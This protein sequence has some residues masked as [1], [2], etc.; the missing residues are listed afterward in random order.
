[1]DGTVRL[2]GIANFRG[3]GG[4]SAGKGWRVAPGRLYRSGSLH[5]MTD[6]DRAALERFAIRTIVDL[7]CEWERN[8]QPY[9]VDFARVVPAPLAD[10]DRAR[11]ITERFLRGEV[12]SAELESWW[13]LTGMY[14]AP[15]Q[16]A[17]AIGRVFD[18]I[19]LLGNGAALLFHCRG[20]KDRTGLMAALVLHA[21]GVDRAAILDDFLLSG[22]LAPPAMETGE[23]RL[24]NR[25]LESMD[26]TAAARRAVTSVQAEWLEA[27][28]GGI[29]QRYGSV[30]GYLGRRVG[31]GQDDLTRLRRGFLEPDDGARTGGG[32]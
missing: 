17:R 29:E 8:A 31:L 19:L 5:E 4:V 11:S 13:D 27:L 22:A 7:R 32:P 12:G 21:L 30:T 15:E 28:L 1:M 26:L 14:E 18:E 20:G 10:D 6:G 2:E 24:M 25:L 23:T 16:H 3:L 9:R